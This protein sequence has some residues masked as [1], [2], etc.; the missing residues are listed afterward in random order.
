MT[1]P[2]RRSSTSDARIAG[3]L[4][5][6][7]SLGIVLIAGAAESRDGIR[8]LQAVSQVKAANAESDLGEVADRQR[9][10]VA[11]KKRVRAVR[12]TKASKDLPS[13]PHLAPAPDRAVRTK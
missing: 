6:G 1:E 2:R 9:D 5:A 3:V 8:S 13:K 12:R 7:L 4:I 10:L 11:Q